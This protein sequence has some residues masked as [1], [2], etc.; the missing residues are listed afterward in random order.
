MA[1]Q[2]IQNNGFT[3]LELMLVVSLLAVL[4]GLG[5]TSLLNWQWRSQYLA[6]LN[7]IAVAVQQAQ[8]HAQR[9]HHDYWLSV[10]GHCIWL[11]THATGQC[12][13]HGVVFQQPYLS[14]QPQFTHGHQLRFMAGRGLSGFGSGRIRLA[15]QRFP[16]HEAAVIVSSLGRVRVCENEP[17]LRGVPLC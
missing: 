17:L 14:W 5:A 2:H 4:G 8:R 11:H 6:K 16:S 7:A 1:E 13:A 10:E 12:E 3:L 15:H 9:G